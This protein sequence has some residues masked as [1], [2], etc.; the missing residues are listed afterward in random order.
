[1]NLFW[2]LKT[3]L[4]F[5]FGTDIATW[6]QHTFISCE[7]KLCLRV[8]KCSSTSIFYGIFKVCDHE[9]WPAY[10]L[11]KAIA[12]SHHFALKIESKSIKNHWLEQLNLLIASEINFCHRFVGFWTQIG[13]HSG[14]QIRLQITLN[15]LRTHK[16]LP[17]AAKSVQEAAKSLESVS[18]KRSE[19]V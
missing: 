4:S 18:S 3:G 19:A 16:K 6:A 13:S 8:K 2:V 9:R 15:R 5:H 7:K 10:R 12:K 17:R 14:A 1:M 11:S